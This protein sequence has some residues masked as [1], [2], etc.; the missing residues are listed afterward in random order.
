MKDNSQSEQKLSKR[1]CTTNI[2][3]KFVNHVK[4]EK[5]F[6]YMMQLFTSTSNQ[7]DVC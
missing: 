7:D 1:N 3:I 4:F 2:G 5:L 6:E